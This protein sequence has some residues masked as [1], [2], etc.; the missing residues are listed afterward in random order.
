MEKETP[1][2]I[3]REGMAMIKAQISQ[4][5][6]KNRK[7]KE[8][9]QEMRESIV[10]DLMSIM[11]TRRI[12]IEQLGKGNI[13]SI[14]LE[15]FQELLAKRATHLIKKEEEL[16]TLEDLLGGH[17]AVLE[18]AASACEELEEKIKIIELLHADPT[19]AMSGIFQ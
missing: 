14:M 3:S 12:V 17:E 8:S 15:T 4:L 2:F 16:I 7:M 18:H 19:F 1:R 10:A 11:K 13:E 9:M 6:I 5:T